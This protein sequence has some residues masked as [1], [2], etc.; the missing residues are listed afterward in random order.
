MRMKR[1]RV[2]WWLLVTL[3]AVLVVQGEVPAVMAD[4]CDTLTL[5][6]VSSEA[7]TVSN[8]AV[9][10]TAAKLNPVGKPPAKYAVVTV[11]GDA[12]NWWDDGTVPTATSGHIVPANTTFYVCQSSVLR[13]FLMIRVTTDA[14]ATVSYYGALP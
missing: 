2:S 12:I 7:F 11:T 10:F 9:G 5:G 8:T 1:S 4:A 13:D 6:V 14:K 3:A